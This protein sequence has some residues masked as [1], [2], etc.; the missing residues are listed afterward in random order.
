MTDALATALDV[1]APGRRSCD[2]GPGLVSRMDDK[3]TRTAVERYVELTVFLEG[4][5]LPPMTQDEFDW[6]IRLRAGA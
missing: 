3:A 5:D 4:G 2:S 1:A 6:A